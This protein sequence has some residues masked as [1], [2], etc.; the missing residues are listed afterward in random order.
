VV[1][2]V[3][4]EIEARAE[5][6][7]LESCRKSLT[8]FLPL[9][10]KT[11]TGAAAFAPPHLRRVIWAIEHDEIGHTVVV[12]PPGSAKTNTMIAACAWWLGK[13]PQQHIG[14]ISNTAAQAYRRSVAVRDTVEAGRAYRAVFPNV[15]PDKTKGWSESEWYLQRED[16]SD[17]DATFTAMGV[18]GPLLGARL[19]RVVLDDIADAENMATEGQREKVIDWLSRTLMSRLTP[20]GRVFMI[21]NRWHEKDPVAW[22]QERGW[23]MI[24]LPAVH[25]GRSYWPERWPADFF[26]C[27]GEE[28]KDPPRCCEKARLGARL[29]NLMYQNQ[30]TSDEGAYFK[31]TWWRAY[32]PEDVAWMWQEGKL[33]G[34][35]FVDTAQT[36]NASSD[37]SV[38]ASWLT[39]GSRGYLWELRRGR[40]TFPELI[41]QCIEAQ[42]SLHMAPIYIEEVPWSL[43][44][45]QSLRT[46]NPGVI[47]WR[48]GQRVQ[49]QNKSKAGRAAAASPFAEAGNLYLP[50]TAPW[51]DD[52]IE[53]H[54]VFPNGAH[55]DCVDTTVMFCLEMLARRQ[56]V[57][58]MR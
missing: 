42:K 54:A 45:I 38:V 20:K 32:R 43:P 24:T 17:K 57:F 21:A 40:W 25:D 34:G 51:K 53:E 3:K 7:L 12:M 23:H 15:R 26:V 58:G 44:L 33:R 6:G 48:I 29:F 36:Q 14:Y 8:L 52:F 50:H 30:V 47:G 11:D 13:D 1:T 9:V 56:L 35:I 49:S 55:D 31:R 28:H 5:A 16:I 19:D 46:T 39:D 18:G 4:D 2:K 27:E 22:A 10:F 37:Y 41:A